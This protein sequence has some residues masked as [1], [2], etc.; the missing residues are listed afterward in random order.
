MGAWEEGIEWSHQQGHNS[1]K[2]ILEQIL[3]ERQVCSSL[4]ESSYER[5]LSLDTNMVQTKS[6]HLRWSVVHHVFWLLKL[7]LVQPTF[8][9][10]SYT[11]N[12]SNSQINSMASEP[13]LCQS[14]GVQ[15]PW[16]GR[17]VHELTRF[18]SIDLVCLSTFQVS[19][20]CTF[21][22]LDLG[23]ADNQMIFHRGS[24]LYLQ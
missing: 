17:Q 4:H 6:T 5:S 9:F 2:N 19:E 14:M 16:S 23:V 13:G 7:I 11:L 24:K 1:V 18:P 3:L 8:H 15:G 21:P 20:T 22:G 10:A 12:I